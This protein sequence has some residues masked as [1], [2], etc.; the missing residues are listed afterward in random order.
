[1]DLGGRLCYAAPM[2]R[3]TVRRFSLQ[4]L[5]C[6]VNQY[7]CRAL[8]EAWTSQGLE[9]TDDPDQAD[10]LVLCTCCVTARAEAES[11]R[12]ARGLVR[13]AA[14]GARVVVTGCAASVAPRVFAG[15]GA[16]PVA[17]KAALA[18]DPEG[19]EPG[20][21]PP[22]YPDLP[23]SGHDRARALLKIQDGCSHGCA[24]CIV[25]TARGASRS[26]PMADILAEAERLVLAGH[27]ELGLTGINLGHF[28]R[29]LS[30][31]TS[32]WALVAELERFLTG[33]FEPGRVRLRLGSLDP[34]ILDGTGVA[35]L[36]RSRLVCPHLHISLQSAD[37]GVLAAMGRREGD[38]RA[39]SS[40]LDEMS[41]VW[42]RLG[43]GLDVMTGFPG[44]TEAA[45]ENTA[46]FLE[47]IPVSYAHVFPFSRRPG[48][49]AATMA[50]QVPRPVAI[51]RAARLRRIVADRTDR[52]VEALL[53]ARPPLTVALEGEIPAKGTC[54]Y[55]LD[56]RFL[57]DPQAPAGALV[58]AAP[59]G[60][61]GDTL[62]VA[63]DTEAGPA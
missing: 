33:R 3:H 36:S 41:R 17:D 44:E 11:R 6:K 45:F 15:L 52:F 56:C 63:P 32:L 7:E 12:L 30:P 25:P 40:F 58:R 49:R 51:D 62:L 48:T 46:A 24:Y 37:P 43:L 60:R 23:V 22:D 61:D 10:L 29:D 27:G 1:M 16:V 59:V 19:A 18:R 26:R 47:R 14:P 21:V 50:G 20:P 8:V 54:Q 13:R 4:S 34:S 28:G 39:V 53:L 38:A 5:G 31:A 2:P 9:Q 57:A 35:V 55:Y 42:P